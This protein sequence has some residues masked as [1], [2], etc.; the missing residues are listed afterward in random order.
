[1]PTWHCG[2]YTVYSQIISSN[3]NGYLKEHPGAWPWC[4]ETGY[5]K[6]FGLNGTADVQDTLYAGLL[7]A[8]CS[9]GLFAMEHR[10]GMQ[11]ILCA[12]PLGRRKTVQAKLGQSALLAVVIAMGTCLPHLWQILRDYGLPALDAPAMSISEFS[13]LPKAVTLGGLLLFWF[14]CRAAACLLMA[15]LTLW[16]GQQFGSFLPAMFVSAAAYCLPPLLALSGMKGGI[17]WLGTYPL[18]HGAA[19]L[20]VQGYGTMDGSP[21]SL[22]WAVML[23]LLLAL[24]AAWALSQ[25]LIGQYEWSGIQ[26]E[27][28]A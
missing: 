1:M 3:I 2:E 23:I 18:F 16:L 19:L 11:Q 20:A 26:L 28:T 8:V 27:G 17:E 9:A 10:G 22:A 7:C 6:L 4:I 5:R 21:Y 13:T 15:M 25:H 24:A 12:T 14:A